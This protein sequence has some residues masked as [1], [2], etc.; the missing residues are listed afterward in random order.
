V[1]QRELGT[2]LRELRNGL[3]LTV[4]EVGISRKITP[5]VLDERVEVRLRRQQLLEREIPLRVPA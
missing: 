1:R 4:E 3:G 2:R 5:K